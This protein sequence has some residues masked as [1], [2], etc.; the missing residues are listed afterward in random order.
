M[1]VCEME[2]NYKVPMIFWLK[3]TDYMHGWLQ[4]ELGG[5]ARVKEQRVV[6][7]HHLPGAKQALRMETVEDLMEKQPVK[8]A[9][10]ARR[11]NCL[12]AGMGVDAEVMRL[13]YGVTE[14]CLR[15]FVPMEAPRMCMT[16]NGVLRPWTVDVSLGDRQAVALQN[17]VRSA[18]WRAVEGFNGRFAREREDKHYAAVEMI[19]AFCRETE[20]PEVH[21]DAMRREWQRRQRKSHAAT[22]SLLS[23]AGAVEGDATGVGAQAVE[24]TG[25][26]A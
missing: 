7:V 26:V 22:T 12:A 13:E 20:T 15:N 1:F 6:S 17:V 4:H 16:R 10:S 18:F 25:A 24:D 23:E 2:K 19:E 9:M 5:S 14:E 21:V 3:V 8:E 11:R